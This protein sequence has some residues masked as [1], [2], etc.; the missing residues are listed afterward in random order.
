MRPRF[1][2]RIR[3]PVTSL[4]QSEQIC[5]LK[6]G[7]LMKLVS[8]TCLAFGAAILAGCGGGGSGG[9]GEAARQ[10]AALDLLERAVSTD[11]TPEA[12]M[13]SS[14]TASYAGYAGF[15]EGG[16]FDRSSVMALGD[17][18]M[19]ADFAGSS[20]SGRIDGLRDVA[21]GR[22]MPG[23]VDLTG[24]ISG[25]EMSGT[26]RGAVDRG[27]TTGDFE[28]GFG[29]AAHDLVGGTISGDVNGTNF[30]GIFVG[31]KR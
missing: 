29:G 9:G 17:F 28:G 11:E 14:G 20:V 6:K 19:T 18:A 31:E 24:S 2:P 10:D 5:W 27:R 7:F 1:R 13:P 21:N 12:A 3:A 26:L 15:S 16:S 4:P 23:G 22:R 30:G 8:L 25:N